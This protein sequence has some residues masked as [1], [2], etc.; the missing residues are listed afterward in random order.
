MNTILW[1]SFFI[2]IIIL[3]IIDLFVLH[4]KDKEISVKR[5]LIESAGWIT[6]ALLFNVVVY[7]TLG[8]AKAVEYLTAYLIEKSLSVDNLFVFIIILAITVCQKHCNIEFFFG[9]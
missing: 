7:F 5:A 3:L 8:T 6:I 9:E 2:I 1:I 4:K